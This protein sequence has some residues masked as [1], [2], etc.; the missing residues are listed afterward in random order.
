MYFFVNDSDFDRLSLLQLHFNSR[1]LETNFK[2][3]SVSFS[4]S[5]N[6]PYDLLV[7]AD[8]VRSAVR[9]EFLKQRDFDYQQRSVDNAWKVLHVPRPPS[10]AGDAVHNYRFQRPG[11]ALLFLLADEGV[12]RLYLLKR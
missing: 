12:L 3:N 1:C 5:E 4:E 8:G 9:L 10:I 2:A 11:T 7:G 6:V